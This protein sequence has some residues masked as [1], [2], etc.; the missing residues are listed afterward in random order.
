MKALLVHGL[1][2]AAVFVACSSESG[3]AAKQASAAPAVAVDPS[4]A[5]LNAKL[6]KLGESL[7]AFTSLTLDGRE[8]DAEALHGRTVLLNLW[9]KH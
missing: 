4:L 5:R 2:A 8:V 7:P 3:S 9:F 6:P 1:L